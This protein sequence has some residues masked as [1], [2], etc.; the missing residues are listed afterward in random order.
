MGENQ[1]HTIV[2]SLVILALLKS[3]TKGSKSHNDHH[4]ASSA[5]RNFLDVLELT[6]AKG[7]YLKTSSS[8]FSKTNL[9][10]N[11]LYHR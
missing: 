3:V 10:R 11:V 6:F 4:S 7:L 1:T 2:I 9:F 8:S 5:W